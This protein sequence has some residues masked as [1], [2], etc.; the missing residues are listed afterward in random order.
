MSL[1]LL[2]FVYITVGEKNKNRKTSFFFFF[3][4]AS[5]ISA[6]VHVGAFL[7][8]PRCVQSS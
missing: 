2:G 4:N 5:T 1:Y 6:G 8:A 7:T 3:F